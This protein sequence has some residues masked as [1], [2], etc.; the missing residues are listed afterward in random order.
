MSKPHDGGRAFPQVG[1]FDNH[2]NALDP[3][4]SMRQYYAAKA[5]EALIIRGVPLEEIPEE[6]FE[7]ADCMIGME[8]R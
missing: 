4:M 8:G 2:G 6:A 1:E 3:G 5:M 7:Q